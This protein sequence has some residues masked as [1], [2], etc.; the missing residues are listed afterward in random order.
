MDASMT[1]NIQLIVLEQHGNNT[2][3]RLTREHVP[4]ITP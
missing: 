3:S 1:Q 4:K 2:I